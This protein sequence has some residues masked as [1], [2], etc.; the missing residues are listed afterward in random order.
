MRLLVPLPDRALLPLLGALLLGCL[1]LALQVGPV[2][3]DFARA[4]LA[5]GDSIEG[6]ILW[7]VRLPRALLAICVGAT[8]GM[9]GAALQG[10]L[11][12]PLASPGLVGVSNCAALGAVLVLYSGLALHAWYI[13]PLAGMTGAVLSVMLVFLLAGRRSSVLTLILAGVAIN[14]VVA[15]LISLVLNLA[16]NPFAVSE[17]TYWLL[18]SIADRSFQDVAV[19]LPFMLAGWALILSGGRYLD[20]LSLGEDTA[21]TLG[22]AD[23]RVR[24]RLIIGVAACVGAAVSV[25]GTIGFVGLVVPHLLRPWVG[26]EPRRLL[27]ASALGGALLLLL[28]DIAVQWISPHQD[29]KLGV[30]TALIGGPVF[31]HLIYRTRN[32]LL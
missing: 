13:L 1:L 24:W 9:A 6:L 31:L 17:I 10:M 27:A 5:P 18:G 7:Q 22:F 21:R 14:S 26:H 29:L 2:R 28:A 30:V 11:R 16:P 20:A 23:T 19:A 25:S 3:L 4:L 32:R 15:S 8:L 12:N